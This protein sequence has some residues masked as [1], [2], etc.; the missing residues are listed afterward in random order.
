[1]LGCEIGTSTL[2]TSST[3]YMHAVYGAVLFVRCFRDAEKA[4]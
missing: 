3:R 1:M 4:T 2:G